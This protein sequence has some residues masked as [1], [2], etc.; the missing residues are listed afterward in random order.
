MKMSMYYVIVLLLFP[1]LM[2][3]S[4]AQA[5]K[6]YNEGTVTYN[7]VVST[8][9]TETKAADLLDGAVMRLYVK[10]MQTR[11]D[12]KSILGTTITL[13]DARSGA[14]V[15]LNEYG[16]QKIMIRMNK[17]E[18][19]DR[20]KKFSGL[21]FE[22]KNETKTILGYT[23]KLAV[24]TLTDGTTFRVFYAPDLVF[25]NK[26]YGQQFQSLPGFPLEYESE[27]GKMKVTY[28]AEK[29]LFD[30]ITAAFFDIPK[31]GYR[32]MSYEEVKKTQN[33]N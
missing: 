7:I 19:E 25:Q 2:A 11:T 9:N 10:G 24:V 15:V 20:N 17:D 33:R 5:Q 28:V 26:N 30:P 3:V 22:L 6:I 32:E 23:C 4:P 29:V 12:L 31:T 27:L 18:Y 13:H 1:L 21:K 16:D 8:G 14:A